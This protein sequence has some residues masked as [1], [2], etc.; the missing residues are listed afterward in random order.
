VKGTTAPER[1]ITFLMR[2]MQQNSFR[3]VDYT[4]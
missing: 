4:K 1:L 2:A 3:Y